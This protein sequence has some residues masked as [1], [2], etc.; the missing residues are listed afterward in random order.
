MEGEAYL[1]TPPVIPNE[2]F[3]ILGWWKAHEEDYPLLAQVAKDI[4]AIPVAEVGVE[5]VFNMAKD[6]IGDRRHRLAAKTIQQIMI[7]KDSISHEMDDG[8]FDLDSPDRDGDQAP[9][10]EVTELFN[11]DSPT[12]EPRHRQDL[13]NDLDQ[14]LDIGITE[15]ISQDDRPALRPPQSRKRPARYLDS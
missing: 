3:T 6:V 11:L 15:T 2:S 5:R 4:L 10:D 1:S 14:S 9:Y 7:L 12:T 8:L 13:D